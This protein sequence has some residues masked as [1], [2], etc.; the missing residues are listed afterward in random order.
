[1]RGGRTSFFEIFKI[2]RREVVEYAAAIIFHPPPPGGD[3]PW[4][5]QEGSDKV[6]ILE[7]FGMTQKNFLTNR[8]INNIIFPKLIPKSYFESLGPHLP[9][10]DDCFIRCAS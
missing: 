1:M 2:E 6:K 5:A 3:P 9:F 4:Y 10:C 8:K 7:I